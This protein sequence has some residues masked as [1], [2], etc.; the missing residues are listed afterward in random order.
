MAAPEYN[1]R[2]YIE[3][4]YWASAGAQVYNRGPGAEPPASVQGAVPL[5]GSQGAKPPQ[6]DGILVLEHMSGDLLNLKAGPKISRESYC[7]LI[8]FR[9]GL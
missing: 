4:D 3:P 6:A 2:V 1:S 5:V 8:T 9:L 7:I